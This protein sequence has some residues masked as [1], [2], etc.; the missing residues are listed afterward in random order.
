MPS[1][2]EKVFRQLLTAVE[3][4][5]GIQ[6]LSVFTTFGINSPTGEAS[7]LAGRYFSKSVTVAKKNGVLSNGLRSAFSYA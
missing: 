2:H 4:P 3:K 7:T 6:K 5:Y 1:N